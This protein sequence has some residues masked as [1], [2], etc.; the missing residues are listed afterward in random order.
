MR[1]LSC[2]LVILGL[3]LFVVGCGETTSQDPATPVED[4]TT[5][6]METD[7]TT[8]PMGTEEG[9]TEESGTE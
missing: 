5:D 2:L 7:E 1:I 9:G 4:E 3:G 8:D 6:P